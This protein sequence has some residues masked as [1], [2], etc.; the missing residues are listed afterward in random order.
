MTTMIDTRPQEILVRN[1][2]FETLTQTLVSMREQSGTQALADLA[3]AFTASRGYK[4]HSRKLVL[5]EGTA[6][7]LRSV[8]SQTDIPESRQQTVTDK[9]D[10]AFPVTA[11]AVADRPDEDG[12]EQDG[13][14]E[15]PQTEQQPTTVPAQADEPQ[16]PTVAPNAPQTETPP[17][18]NVPEGDK[19]NAEGVFEPD[20]GRTPISI[21]HVSPQRTVP[22]IS[23]TALVQTVTVPDLSKYPVAHGK[24]G[25]VRYRSKS[26]ASGGFVSIVDLEKLP[27]ANFGIESVPEQATALVVCELHGLAAPLPRVRPGKYYLRAPERFCSSCASGLKAERPQPTETP[28]RGRKP[29][30]EAPVVVDNRVTVVEEPKVDAEVSLHPSDERADESAWNEFSQALAASEKATVMWVGNRQYALNYG[31]G[32]NVEVYV[33]AQ[34]VENRWRV[35]ESD[36]TSLE[37]AKAALAE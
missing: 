37:T 20:M 8:F 15:Q 4:G 34:G 3:D 31:D 6:T 11:T 7:A 21:I 9:L 17:A 14:T 5:D 32:K 26:R 22:N 1:D 2:I 27:I 13:P 25:T 19:P 24:S 29:K 30:D 28:K 10:A 35:G 23:K 16:Q 33:N 12:A 36:F 18:P